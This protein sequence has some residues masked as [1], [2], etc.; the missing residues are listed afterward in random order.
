MLEETLIIDLDHIGLILQDR[1]KLY[2]PRGK[3]LNFSSFL[4]PKT[5]LERIIE[6]K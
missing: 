6:N 3:A 2:S 4:I 5:A 1:N